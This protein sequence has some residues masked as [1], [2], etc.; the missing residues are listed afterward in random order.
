MNLLIIIVLHNR[1]IINLAAIIGLLI[2]YVPVKTSCYNC[3]LKKEG[4]CNFLQSYCGFLRCYL[5]IIDVLIVTKFV[6]FIF[7]NLWWSRQK[8]DI[9][10]LSLQGLNLTD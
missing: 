1:K 2:N 3:E 9:S 10:S 8:L 6:A 4:E 5:H 7:S